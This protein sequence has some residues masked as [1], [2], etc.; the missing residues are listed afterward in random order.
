MSTDTH[1]ARVADAARAV[2][3]DHP[4]R[5]VPAAEFFGACYDAG[6]SWIHFPEG[7]GGL[8]LSRGLQGVA[9]AVFQEAGAPSPYDLNIIGYGMAAP[10][11]V[12]HAQTEELK[13]Q[14]L[15]P[16]ASTEDIWC[17]LFSEPGAGS[18]LAGLA[19][20][21]VRDGDDWVVNGQK[22]WTTLAHCSRWAIL[23]ARTD[24]DMPKHKGLTYFVVDM[25]SPGVDVRPLRQMTG[26]AEFNEVYLNDVRVPDA[27]RLGAVGGGWGVAMTTLMNERSTIGAAGLRRGY[28]TIAD[29]VALWAQRPELRTPVKRDHLTELWLRAEAQRLTSERARVSATV[30]GPGP[31]GSIDKLVG[32]E[33][34]QR[35]Y[36]FCMDLL[37]AESTLYHDYSMREITAENANVGGPVQE[38][39]LRSRANTIEGG[40]SEVLRNILGERILGLPGDLRA[41]SGRPWREV[42]RG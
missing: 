28:G 26:Q 39:F 38:R 3:R 1:A 32:A 13:R 31:E 42:P 34:N 9:D 17:Q 11:V 16:L 14:W 19:T 30:R 41:D 37:G 21:A 12:E 35:I 24:P 6:L 20:S 2:V 18:D 15:R 7:L 10:T 33:L 29:A 22:V 36:E 23:I 5:E 40:T 4:P 25:N 27:Y 8:G